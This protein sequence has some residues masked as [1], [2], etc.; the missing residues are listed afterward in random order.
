MGLISSLAAP[1][2]PQF[3]SLT[4]KPVAR[5][6][7][8]L[9]TPRP[10][11]PAAADATL[12]RRGGAEPPPKL[13]AHPILSPNASDAV[14]KG[15]LP[16]QPAMAQAASAVQGEADQIEPLTEVDGISLDG[17]PYL[18]DGAVL[19]D[20]L[21]QTEPEP[22]PKAK[23]AAADIM[24]LPSPTP[25]RPELGP[26][27]AGQ[28]EP[29]ALRANQAERAYL[30]EREISAV[31]AELATPLDPQAATQETGATLAVDQ[32]DAAAAP[33]VDKRA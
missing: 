12:R 20:D 32:P 9:M 26:E 19:L 10:E 14:F 24:A 21:P 22:A 5:V 2:A 29:E 31:R 16:M 17:I 1:S 18:R 25:L 11:T 7:A 3:Q 27:L 8:A 28:A 30:E 4:I 6:T 23:P 15:L 13:A 33:S